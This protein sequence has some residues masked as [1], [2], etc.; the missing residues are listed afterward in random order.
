[1]QSFPEILCV[2]SDRIK[3][4][5]FVRS[6]FYCNCSGFGLRCNQQ[7]ADDRRMACFMEVLEIKGIVEYL[8]NSFSVI[9]SF[10][11]FELQDEDHWS[12]KKHHIDTTTHAWDGI[13]EMYPSLKMS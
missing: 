3:N 1:M 10:P 7:G 4:T 12:D 13:L 5:V 6:F 11:Y 8:V 9:S 2:A